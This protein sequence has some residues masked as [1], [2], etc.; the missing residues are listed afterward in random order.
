MHSSL[1]A[2]LC[3]IGTGMNRGLLI[4]VV[5]IASSGENAEMLRTISP[6]FSTAGDGQV[7]DGL[8][9]ASISR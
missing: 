5:S 1:F 6:G 3:W 4:S 2:L 8:G 9:T 7:G